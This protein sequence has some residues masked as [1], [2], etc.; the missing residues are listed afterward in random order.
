MD[1]TKIE[2]FASA[3]IDYCDA[4][5]CDYEC[6]M[7]QAMGINR[8]SEECLGHALLNV[9]LSV[10]ILQE[11]LA[12]QPFV[13][14]PGEIYYYIRPDGSIDYYHCSGEGELFE[15]ALRLMGN[16]FRSELEAEMHK[17]E[18]LGKFYALKEGRW[19]Y[20]GDNDA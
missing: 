11:H 4:N 12:N 10:P 9:D 1:L 20:W 18:I 16:C 13:P 6:K 7:A 17:G 14:S 19:P 2:D 5:V 15:Y 8:S 3:F